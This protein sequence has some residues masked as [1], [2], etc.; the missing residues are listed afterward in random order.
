MKDCLGLLRRVPVA[1][2]NKG[3]SSAAKRI[4]TGRTYITAIYTELLHGARPSSSRKDA[5]S[6]SP[7]M[8]TEVEA[9]P[10]SGAAGD[11][12]YS[13]ICRHLCES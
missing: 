11:E 12:S 10:S 8:P 5:V 13:L 9:H 3:L 7:E 2:D 6:L 4:G 1:A